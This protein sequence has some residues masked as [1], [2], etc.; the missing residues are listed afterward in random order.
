MSVFPKLLRRLEQ[1]VID[2]VIVVLAGVSRVVTADLRASF[3]GSAHMIGLQML[4]VAWDQQIPRRTVDEDREWAMHH[5]PS[6]VVEL[7]PGLR[8]VNPHREIAT[9]SRR[10]VA[11]ENFAG[12]QRFSSHRGLCG[13]FHSSGSKVQNANGS[14]TSLSDCC[15]MG[16]LGPLNSSLDRLT[17][18]TFRAFP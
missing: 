1:L 7:F 9:T 17:E 18:F 4:T 15:S 14:W 10:T 3:V 11:A 2:A 16:T 8:R 12:L 5:V 6:H 13:C